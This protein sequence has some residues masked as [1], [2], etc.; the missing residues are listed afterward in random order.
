MPG[1]EMGGGGKAEE[2]A[3]AMTCLWV[4]ALQ[5]ADEELALVNHLGREVVVKVDE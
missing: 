3:T 2:P 5:P 4:R 1:R